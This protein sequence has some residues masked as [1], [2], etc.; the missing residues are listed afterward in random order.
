[1]NNTNNVIQKVSKKKQYPRVAT[2]KVTAGKTK[3]TG[4][5]KLRRKPHSMK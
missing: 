1:M 4:R 3:K 5:A 2:G